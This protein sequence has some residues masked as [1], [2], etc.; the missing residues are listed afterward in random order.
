MKADFVWKCLPVLCLIKSVVTSWESW[1]TY[2]GISGP[3]FWGRLNPKWSLCSRGRRQ[4]PIDI[5][6]KLLL[7]DPNLSP[8]HVYGDYISGNLQNSGRGIIFK[9]SSNRT[10]IIS[11]GPLS[12][13]YTLKEMILH[14]GRENDRGS[15]H[16]ISGHQFPAEIQLYAFNSQLYANW[17]TAQSEANG[18]LAIAVLIAHTQQSIGGNAQL[19]HITHT[20]KNI[21]AK[22][23]NQWISSLSIRELL[24]TLKYYITYEGSLTQPSCH[25]TVTWIVL[26]KPIYMT[27]HQFHQLRTTMH[28]DGHGDNFR[29]LQPINHRVMRTSINFQDQTN[30]VSIDFKQ[31]HH[32]KA[33]MCTMERSMM[34]RGKG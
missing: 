31:S 9:V 23:D 13:Q 3:D 7:F 1:W 12:Y 16:T 18:V 24:P 10:V 14:Y 4:S 15:E 33:S 25:E 11:G 19:K 21:T 22:G 20:L 6:P 5:N 8:L 27:G 28:S 26:N 32:K 17:T 30:E 34:Y 29:P 2:E